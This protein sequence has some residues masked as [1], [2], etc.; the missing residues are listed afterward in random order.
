MDDQDRVT[1]AAI[2]RRAGV[3][4]AAVSNWRR[5][6]PHF[7]EPVGGTASS[8]V[9]SWEEVLKWLHDT[10][11]AGQ[12]VTMGRT[13][14]G[15]Q[16]IDDA[17][18]VA[19]LSAAVPQ[20][21]AIADL[22]PRQLLARVMAAVLP[23]PGTEDPDDGEPPVVLDPACGAGALLL[24][25]A[26]RFGDQV[27]LVGQEVEEEVAARAA[28][29]LRNHPHAPLHDVQKGDSLL[30]SH[31][32]RYLGAAAAVAC[33]PPGNVRQW[34]VA[35]LAA[36][37]RWRFG[38]PDA[39]D[40]ELAWVQHCYAHLRPRGVAV[41]A[42][43][44]PTCTRPSGQ[45]VRAELVRSGVLRDV[46]A[47]PKGVGSAGDGLH[48]WVLQRPYG[49]WDGGPVR[50]VDLSGLAD[51]ADVPHENGAWNRLFADADPAVVRSVPR[52]DLLDG[53][54]ALLPSRYLSSRQAAAA[55]D[56]A[57]LTARLRAAYSRLG[58]ALPRPASA[59][60]RPERP[61]VTIAEL[62]RS[63]ALTIRPRDTTPR[64]GDVLIRNLGRPPVVAQGSPSDENGVAQ[65]IEI[66]PVRLDPHFLA[67]FLRADAGV[68][69][70]ANTHGALSRDDLRRCRLPRM[71]LAEQRRYG[72][73]FRHLLDLQE[74]VEALATVSAGVLDQTIHSLTTGAL[75]PQLHPARES[76]SADPT[77]SEST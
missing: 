54:T 34:P 59:T 72:E 13:D 30:D 1:A 2:A 58:R 3:G 47:L 23:Y 22:E 27:K 14:T 32:A 19:E 28:A 55:D 29:E 8:P 44:L 17:G 65:V 76:I 64:R 37:P 66:D 73:S 57:D 7:P 12:L 74:A 5:R 10:G 35:E 52:L 67:M 25:V 46:I 70:V 24:A 56:L 9:F 42:V 53:D 38:I 50:M 18:P 16:R 21:R 60:P 31:L 69:P 41:V 45:V 4:R 48:L 20:E 36:D 77:E 71:P 61:Q 39:G 75:A 40:P 63:A 49:A 68:L 6:Y 11:K 33:I 62:E 26:D 15:T 51:P 43:L